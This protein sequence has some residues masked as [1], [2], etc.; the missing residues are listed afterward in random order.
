MQIVP[1]APEHAV[2]AR[3][4]NARMQAANAPTAFYLPEEAPALASGE[5]ITWTHHVVL[6]GQ[7]IRGGLLEMDQPA[8]LQGA[9]VRASNYQSPLSEGI[10]DRKFANV[11]LRLVRFMESR[12]HAYMVGRG[13]ESN[14]VPGLLK[15]GGWSVESAPFLFRVHRASRFLRE[16]KIAHATPARSALA[17]MAAATGIGRVGLAAAHWRPG[18]GAKKYT[19]RAVESWGAW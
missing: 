4:F 18:R 15:A 19:L 3:P 10:S 11:G 16:M 8:W 12:G 2:S 9:E 14:P 6:D 17:R 1:Y 7:Y 5:A 13:S